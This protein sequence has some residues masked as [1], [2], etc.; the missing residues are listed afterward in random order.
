VRGHDLSALEGVEWNFFS[1]TPPNELATAGHT[2]AEA[3]EAE[4]AALT[5]HYRNNDHHPEYFPDGI[6]G[7]LPDGDVSAAFLEMCVD[8]YVTRR[9]VVSLDDVINAQ[10]QLYNMSNEVASLFRSI[11]T[12]LYQL[13][14]FDMEHTLDKVSR[15]QVGL[16]RG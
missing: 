14:L 2:S 5:H 1:T 15:L 8:V 13:D 3:G 6:A 12:L 7:M 11:I 4:N 10:V 9:A 16:G